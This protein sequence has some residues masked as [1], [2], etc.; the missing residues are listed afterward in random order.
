V[1]NFKSPRGRNARSVSRPLVES[2]EVRLCL[3]TT[4]HLQA[5]QTAMPPPHALTATVR[6][7]GHPVGRPRHLHALVATHQISQGARQHLAWERHNLANLGRGS[8][9][10]RGPGPDQET[11]HNPNNKLTSNVLSAYGGIGS[12]GWTP[13][14]D[15]IA[16]GSQDSVTGQSTVILA[17][18]EQI[19]LFNKSGNPY[20]N[21]NNLYSGNNL[22]I[23]STDPSKQS[24]SLFHASNSAF[25]PRVLFDPANGGHF[26]LTAV[27][28]STRPQSSYLDIAVSKSANPRTAADWYTYRYSV[29][30]TIAKTA[31]WMDFPSLGMDATTLYVTGNMFGF[32][33]GSFRGVKL[34]TFPK[35]TMEAGGAVT[36]PVNTKIFTDG[37][38]S[39][40]PAVTYDSTAPE[41]LI[42]TENGS[43]STTVRLDAITNPLIAGALT[44]AQIYVTVPAYN[45]NV[46]KAPQLGSSNLI[47]TNDA[48]MLS[49][50]FTNGSLW[51]ADTIESTTGKTVA[52]W[53]E[54][55]PAVSSSPTASGNIDPGGSVYTFFPSITAEW[56]GNVGNVAISYAESSPTE[57]PSASFAAAPITTTTSFTPAASP[58]IQ[59]GAAS[60]GGSRWGDYSGIAADPSAPGIFYA[61]G[62]ATQSDGNWGTW[63]TQATPPPT[64]APAT[65]TNLT[66]TAETSGPILLSWNAVAGAAGYTV[67]GSTVSPFTPSTATIVIPTASAQ[68]S[69]ENTNVQPNT[70]YYYYVVATNSSGSSPLQSS[71]SSA[72]ALTTNTVFADSFS[73][74]GE[75]FPAPNWSIAGTS[76][77]ATWKMSSTGGPSPGEGMVSQTSTATGDIKKA[78]VNNQ[79]S[80]GVI[81]TAEVHLDSWADGEL[82]RAGI[83]LFT[84]LSTGQ[85]YNLVLTG[86]HS[87]TGAS[88]VESPQVEFLDDHVVW[89]GALNL[90]SNLSFQVGPN[91]PWYWFQLEAR[92][93][94]LYGSVWQ[95]GTAQPA[96]WMGSQAGWSDHTTGDP[97]LNGGAAGTF[98]NI[99]SYSTA[100]FT[101]VTVTK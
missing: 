1:S 28:Q 69:V 34:I 64:T 24:A 36:G 98:N 47:N 13:P 9:F 58:N 94:V 79:S 31:T 55:N 48:R 33:N 99:T 93:G 84:D 96:T 17:V 60:Y 67:Y 3:S 22:A 74:L 27:E 4:A 77:A 62:E 20:N 70:T 89:G 44:D 25:D 15:N 50:V 59:A 95:D 73:A 90:P 68:T 18:N 19:A 65:P 2:L 83:G 61:V 42:Q 11:V 6:Q 101:S 45:T 38:F 81:I 92:N 14:D 85:G 54:I 29:T 7:D 10:E 43:N 12:T 21:P 71:P 78:I 52:R 76:G 5:F 16:V 40:Q 91:A 23:T 39:M 63:W 88:T 46:T 51:A 72:T 86:R 100:S 53:Y 80:S 26:I 66:A 32:T 49:A 75:T 8:R 37:S 56:S 41:Y 35:I 57:H 82:A 30:Q 87:N 97:A